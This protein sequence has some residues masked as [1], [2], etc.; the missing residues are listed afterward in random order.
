MPRSARSAAAS[1]PRSARSVAAW[2]LLLALPLLVLATRDA[3]GQEP[4]AVQGDA[5]AGA[6]LYS[7]QCAT[8]HGA[9]GGG[10]SVPDD[11]RSAP[12]IDSDNVSLA[13]WDLVLRTGRMPPP[14]R[15]PFDNRHR[16][17][18]YDAEQRADL[19]AFAVEEL[20]VE[21]ELPPAGLGDPGRGLEIYTANCASCHGATGAG[22]VAGG[23]AWTP[24]IAGYDPQTIS[25]AVRVGPFQ[26]P[27]FDDDQISD[28][29][30]ADIAAFLHEVEEEPGTALGLVEL[31]PVYLSGFVA[32]LAAV[33]LAS[34][35]WISG[36]PT[37]FPDSRPEEDEADEAD[38]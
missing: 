16:E 3:G 8:C 34:I 23:G 29:G 1:L 15:E 31:N 5:S 13:Y 38:E 26:M 17:V 35:A 2:S 6:V 7:Q 10:G 24:T 4:E 30:L 27:Q 9:S 36:T 11:P 37:W 21:G 12:A 22:G 33:L 32:L 25:S 20:G 18:R 28:E 14:E 19:N